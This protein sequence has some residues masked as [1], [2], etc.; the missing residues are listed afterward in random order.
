MAAEEGVIESSKN[1]VTSKVALHY[2][3]RYIFIFKIE[4]AAANS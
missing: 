2:I 4:V 1:K 3:E